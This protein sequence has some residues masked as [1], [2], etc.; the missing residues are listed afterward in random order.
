[1]KVF[2]SHMFDGDDES[3][4][5]TLK[6]D[7]GALGMTGYMAKKAQ[8]YDL[9]IHDK[10]RQEI[11]ESGWLVAIIT[12]RSRMSASV[13]EEIGYA[14]GKGVQ[15]ALMVEKDVKEGGVLIYGREQ[16]IFIPREFGVHSK[17][18]AE[19]IKSAPNAAPAHDP[20]GGAAKDLLEKRR[21][22]SVESP[23]F[24]RNEHF[25]GLYSGSLDDAVKPVVLFTACPHDLVD[26]YDVTTPEFMDWEESIVRMD[27]DGQQVHI[28]GGESDVDIGI[29]KIVEKRDGASKNIRL[30][31]EFQSSGFMEWGTSSLFFDRNDRKKT[32]LHLGYMIGELWTFLASARLFYRKIGLDVPFTLLVSIRNSYTLDLGNYGNEIDNSLHHLKLTLSPNSSELTTKHDHIKLSHIFTSV[33]EMSDKN[34]ASVTKKIAKDICNAYGEKN[35]NCYDKSGSFLWNVHDKVSSRA[36]GDGRI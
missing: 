7:L 19:F 26:R 30:Y 12:E 28:L 23:D 13:H 17:R 20:L 5:S 4:A 25:D 18:V 33:R 2:I 29:L 32:E 8:R 6:D 1:M 21:L 14:L 3:F 31:R 35:P 34:I 24:A 15:V 9:M 16:E 36:T 10:I 11:E 27:V 22:L